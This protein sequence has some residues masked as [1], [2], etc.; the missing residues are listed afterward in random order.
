MLSSAITV[1]LM[2]ELSCFMCQYFNQSALI[3]LNCMLVRLWCSGYC[4]KPF[5][6]LGGWVPVSYSIAMIVIFLAHLWFDS[7]VAFDTDCSGRPKLWVWI[8]NKKHPQAFWITQGKQSISTK[9]T[10]RACC[11]TVMSHLIS[12]QGQRLVQMKVKRWAH[13]KCMT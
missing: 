5:V 9:G 8:R 11:A 6:E 10:Q 3:L 1:M 2:S 12:Q 13:W 7:A 4:L